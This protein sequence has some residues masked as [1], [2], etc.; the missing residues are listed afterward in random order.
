MKNSFEITWNC[1]DNNPP[2]YGGRFW[3]VVEEINALG[4]STFQWN[5]GYDEIENNWYDNGISMRV[6]YWTEFPSIPNR[7]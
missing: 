5:C 7:N 1:A 2:K 4:K 6:V 3:C